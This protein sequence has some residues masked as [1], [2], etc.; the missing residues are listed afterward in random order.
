MPR[1]GSI[2]P[3][4]FTALPPQS[5]FTHGRARA[6]AV[7]AFADGRAD[8]PGESIS[9]VSM[10]AAGLPAPE[11]QVEIYGASGARYVVDFYW[12]E[13]RLMGEFDGAAKYRDPELLRGR[14]PEQALADEKHREDDLRATARGMS[15]WGWRVANSPVLLGQQLRRAGLR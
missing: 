3:P 10:R 4:T 14:T 9:R 13:R 12:P 1:F 8:R 11:L 6:T 7:A 15:R 2:S 5:L